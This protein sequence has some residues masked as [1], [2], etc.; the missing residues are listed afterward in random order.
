M[1]RIV[2]IQQM[3]LVWPTFTHVSMKTTC[4]PDS[5]ELQSKSV[6]YQNETGHSPPTTFHP[7]RRKHFSINLL[8][9]SLWNK[10]SQF[11]EIQLQKSIKM[12][13]LKW[14]QSTG[15]YFH[16]CRNKRLLEIFSLTVQEHYVQY[17]LI[18]YYYLSL[19]SWFCLANCDKSSNET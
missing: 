14:S 4:W 13:K 2:K 5:T 1:H 18:W 9:G 16:V 11:S 12:K 6:K 17:I 7:D 8:C 3:L 19:Q 10:I 15:R